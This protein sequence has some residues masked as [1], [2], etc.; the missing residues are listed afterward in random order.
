MC[1]SC[2]PVEL[3]KALGHCHIALTQKLTLACAVD[4]PMAMPMAVPMAVPM[5][6]PMDMPMAVSMA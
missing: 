3:A 6:L 1:F 4:V 5:A 2:L